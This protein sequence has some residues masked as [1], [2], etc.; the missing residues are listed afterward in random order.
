MRELPK[1][2]EHSEVDPRWYA[3]WESIGAFRAE[4]GVRQAALQH[5][6]S[7]AQ[8]DR[9]AAHGPR[10][11]PHA[12][13]HHRAVE[14]D[15]GLR[16]PV[17]ARH[18]PRRHRHPERRR[19]AAGAGGEDPPRP[20]PRGVRRAGVGV[21]EAEPRHDHRPDAEARR[22]GRLDA[23]A[24]HAG[25]AAVAGGAPRVRLALR[26]GADLPRHLHRELVPALPH[27]AVRPRGGAQGHDREALVRALSGRGRRRGRGRGHDAA[28]D[29][30]R[31]H[32]GGGE[33]GRRALPGP[34][35]PD[36]SAADHRARADHHR[37]RVRRPGV[38]HRRGEGDAGARS[39]RLPDGEA[40]RPARGGGHRRGRADHAG[41]R[42]VRR[43]RPVQ[44]ARRRRGAAR[45]RGAARR[46]WR[47][48]S[49]PSAPA[50]AAAPWS[51]RW[52]RRSGS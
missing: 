10:A 1:A 49:T 26:G 27:G 25:R 40:A 51:S 19:E 5:G 38:R 15:A 8:R 23:R 24:V 34:D 42:A 28:R 52:C 20:R 39:E 7:A 35:R 16:R 22:I 18:R 9:L 11:Q 2:F 29:D 30:A 43:A 46:R 14:A 4:S 12:A 44:G 13:R 47:T 33:P 6:H 45:G 37:R 3:F 21:G 36:R 50:S 17:A 48:T 31:R 41:R 32:G